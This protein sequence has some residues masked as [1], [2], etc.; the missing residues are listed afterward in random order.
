MHKTVLVR[1]IVFFF[2]SQSE[3]LWSI[4]CNYK[5]FLGC[6]YVIM[7]FN[8][9]LILTLWLGMYI[10]KLRWWYLFPENEIMELG[11]DICNSYLLSLG[12]S[13]TDANM[14]PKQR[15]SCCVSSFF[16]P[17]IYTPIFLQI[18]CC[19]IWVPQNILFQSLQIAMGIEFT[20][21]FAIHY[22]YY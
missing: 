22:Y 7:V 4:S 5:Y 10:R 19:A 6:A 13:P 3:A 21:T 8:T 14:Q 18:Y 17:L 9:P 20:L 12:S 1:P 11:P 16:L 15:C 2:S